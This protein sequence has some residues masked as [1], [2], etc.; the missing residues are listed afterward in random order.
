MDLAACSS[1]EDSPRD[2]VGDD[3][4]RDASLDARDADDAARACSTPAA[5]APWITEVQEG[6]VARLSGK[7]PISSGLIS[8]DRASP[9]RRSAVSAYLRAELSALDVAA[10][11]QKYATGTN[12]YGILEA[13]APSSANIVIGAH[14]DTVPGSPGA[15][16]N[17]T[18][19]AL[20]MA[21]ARYL[22]SVDCRQSNVYFVFFDEEEVGLV[23]SA[24]FA[25]FLKE[26]AVSVTSVHTIDQVGWDKDG[27][28][29]IELERP[30]G[31]LYA[32]WVAS[33]DAAGLTM[34]LHLVGT[35][36][37]DHVSFRANGF[38][39]IGITE[40]HVNGDT[41]PNYHKATD[42]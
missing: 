37:T 26:S 41:S 35:G 24:K 3:G 14:F 23:G 42:T 6:I 31:D 2:S 20:V 7:S 25:A 40:E 36:S 9:A 18:G 4:G 39:A 21:V 15:N 16:D 32:E 27:D 11:L 38:S 29:A 30:S 12:V 22:V 19:V 1:R 34:P 13:S 28:R 10:S 17:A 33:R 5:D 8:S